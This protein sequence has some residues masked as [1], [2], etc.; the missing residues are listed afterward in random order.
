[1]EL[2]DD[3][4]R[5]EGARRRLVQRG[6]V[7]EVEHVCL[8]RPRP[9]E[10]AGPHVDQTLVRLVT[11]GGEHRVGRAGTLL[12]GGLERDPAPRRVVDR[13]DVDPVE[14]RRRVAPSAGV[15]EGPGRER[16]A[17]AKRLERA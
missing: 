12:V 2:A 10:R 8:G 1:V 9:G 4:N 11:D 16:D 17:V 5:R 14:E 3:R 6:E 15:A 7:V 13:D